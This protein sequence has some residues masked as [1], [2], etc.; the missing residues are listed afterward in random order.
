MKRFASL[1]LLL[2]VFLI[3]FMAGS[4]FAGGTATCYN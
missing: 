4:A 3:F 1:G 2:S